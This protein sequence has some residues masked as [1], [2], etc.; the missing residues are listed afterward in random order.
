MMSIYSNKPA[1][2]GVQFRQTMLPRGRS[3]ALHLLHL[4]HLRPLDVL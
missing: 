4:L 1:I 3:E 2:E